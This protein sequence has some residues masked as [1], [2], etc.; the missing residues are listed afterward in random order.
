MFRAH[1]EALDFRLIELCGEAR[2][3][4]PPDGGSAV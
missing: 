1:R 2:E 3:F 4:G